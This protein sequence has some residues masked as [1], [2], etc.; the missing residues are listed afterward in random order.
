MPQ[1]SSGGRQYN[2]TSQKAEVRMTEEEARTS[3]EYRKLHDEFMEL[4]KKVREEANATW[5]A[6]DKY[7]RNSKEAEDAYAKYQKTYSDFQ[8]KYGEMELAR[9]YKNQASVTGGQAVGNYKDVLSNEFGRPSGRRELQKAE[10]ALQ[11]AR[12]KAGW[13]MTSN[14]YSGPSTPEVQAAMEEYLRLR[15]RYGN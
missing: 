3:A 13:K 9:L 5:E 1:P 11:D 2:G 4:D 14:G 8:K 7:G 12:E 10:T 15:E 6:R